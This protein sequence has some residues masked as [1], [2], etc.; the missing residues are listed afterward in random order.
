[1]K[2]ITQKFI[3]KKKKTSNVLKQRLKVVEYVNT[4]FEIKPKILVEKILSH[5]RVNNLLK[6]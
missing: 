4:R 1:M 3:S 5:Q 2:K 6:L